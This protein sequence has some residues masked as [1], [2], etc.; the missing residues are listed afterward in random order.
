[1]GVGKNPQA[2]KP[3][4]FHPSQQLFEFGL[5]FTGVPH[6]QGG[7]NRDS[8]N[9]F[10]HGLNQGIGLCLGGA[11]FHAL[12]HPIHGMLQWNVHV[13]ANL[14]LLADD[15]QH[16]FGK[17][18]REQVMQTDPFDAIHLH[19]RAQEFGKPAFLVQIQSVI[20]Q[21]LGNQNQ[22]DDPFCG[23]FFGFFH[24]LFDR[25][26]NVPAAHKRNGAKRARTVAAL[27][28]F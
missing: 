28:N 4:G 27:G 6:N 17:S 25:L 9:L 22:F 16:I 20:G 12:Q 26:R 15:V 10:A 5:G 7:S 8:R 2:V 19:Q 13:G 18:G 21:I 11:A 14:G 1:M 3:L 24:Q 23:Q